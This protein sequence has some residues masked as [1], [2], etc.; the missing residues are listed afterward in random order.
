MSPAVGVTAIASALFLSTPEAIDSNPVPS[1]PDP[2][3]ANLQSPI[4]HEDFEK[5]QVGVEPEVL[6]IL[7]G[8][9]DK[10]DWT[11]IQFS[12]F[13]AN[14]LPNLALS[15]DPVEKKTL[16]SVSAFGLSRRAAAILSLVSD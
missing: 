4:F 7:D 10:L 14:L 5:V 12:V 16:A 3:H 11:E 8:D 9:F 6:F 2:L 15:S 13:G 1:T